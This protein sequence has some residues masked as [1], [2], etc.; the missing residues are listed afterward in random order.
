M[1]QFT[2]TYLLSQEQ[3]ENYAA[4]YSKFSLPD[5]SL[6]LAGI[7]HDG[8]AKPFMALEAMID[9]QLEDDT[10][11]F[12]ESP[13]I[14]DLHE[15]EAPILFAIH[16]SNVARVKK[17]LK[18]LEQED[19]VAY[20][21]EFYGWDNGSEGMPGAVEFL[22]TALTQLTKQQCWLLMFVL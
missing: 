6:E 9:E 1:S 2:Q 15:K 3:L 11:L 21:T 16:H 5:N 22:K 18:N 4:T 20:Y 12:T 10:D 7:P 8:D 17:V 19:L 14:F 13:Y